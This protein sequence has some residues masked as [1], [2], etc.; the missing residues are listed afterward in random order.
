MYICMYGAWSQLPEF[1]E[2]ILD[3]TKYMLWEFQGDH[4]FGFQ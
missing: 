1:L 3:R 2:G 4:N